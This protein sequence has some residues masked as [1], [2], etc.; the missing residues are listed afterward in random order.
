M[1]KCLS[2]DTKH[3]ARLTR[4]DDSQETVFDVN[5]QL[6]HPDFGLSLDRL[7]PKVCDRSSQRMS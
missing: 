5:F 6:G 4:P 3:N 1:I 7:A 2:E